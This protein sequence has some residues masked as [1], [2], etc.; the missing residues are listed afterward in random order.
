LFKEWIDEQKKILNKLGNF[1]LIADINQMEQEIECNHCKDPISNFF[2]TASKSHYLCLKC[3]KKKGRENAPVHYRIFDIETAEKLYEKV[4][5]TV[6]T[7]F[8]SNNVINDKVS[9]TDLEITGK[10][11]LDA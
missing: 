3:G 10:L 2:I 4:N 6:Q 1:T 8:D 5:K 7:L 9:S 11:L